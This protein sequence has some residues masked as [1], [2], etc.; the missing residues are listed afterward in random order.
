VNLGPWVL[1]L[2]ALSATLS[3][4]VCFLGVLAGVFDP[5]R[6]SYAMALCVFFGLL[7]VLASPFLPR[8]GGPRA[9][10]VQ[11]AELLWIWTIASTCAQLGWEAPFVALSHW[12]DGVTAADTWAWLFWAYG[13]ADS[14]Y[15]IADPFIVCM[16]GVT[17]YVGGPAEIWTLVLFRRGQ[18]QRAARWGLVIAATQLYGTL[19]YFGIEALDGFAHINIGHPV[20]L[21]V[22]FLGLNAL[23]IVLPA[24]SMWA[25]LHVLRTGAPEGLRRQTAPGIPAA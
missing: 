6:A 25:C 24:L 19:L 15:I 7:A 18:L 9:R 23:W 5:H 17:A 10:A 14:R 11:V 13:V 16:E 4:V 3:G 22:K 20:D 2:G 21:W 12:L 1:R 8:A